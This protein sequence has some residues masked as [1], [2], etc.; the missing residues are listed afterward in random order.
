MISDASGEFFSFVAHLLCQF[1]HLLLVAVIGG[2]AMGGVLTLLLGDVLV[3]LLELV[4]L[5]SQCFYILI[6]LPDD[7]LQVN[8]L[9]FL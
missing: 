7:L 2:I 1:E 8:E 5:V 3:A 9:F 6:L 4:Y